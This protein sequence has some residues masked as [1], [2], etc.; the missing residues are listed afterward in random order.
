[1]E[2]LL[3]FIW[4]SYYQPLHLIQVHTNNYATNNFCCNKCN[5]LAL[6]IKV[7]EG[8]VDQMFAC[9]FFIL[10]MKGKDLGRSRWILQVYDWL[11]YSYC[12]WVFSVCDPGTL[13]EDEGMLGKDRIHLIHMPETAVQI[14]EL[15][16]VIVSCNWNAPHSIE[17]NSSM[18]YCGKI[19]VW[20]NS[21]DLMEF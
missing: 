10:L 20:Q 21:I 2:K 15:F 11:Q 1:M 7:K 4:S 18:F 6:G 9:F 16:F 5:Y 13:F 12:Q 14:M 8:M 19:M 3:W 17:R